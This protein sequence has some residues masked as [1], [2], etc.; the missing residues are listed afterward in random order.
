M[1]EKQLRWQLLAAVFLGVVYTLLFQDWASGLNVLLFDLLFLGIVGWLRPELRRTPA[2]VFSAATLLFS[3][4]C[5][6]LVHSWVAS[7]S[8]LICFWWFLGVCQAR[9]LRYLWFSLL[10]GLWSL[11]GGWKRALRYGVAVWRTPDRPSGS[12]RLALPWLRVAVVPMVVVFPFFLFYVAGNAAFAEFV[13]GLADWLGHWSWPDFDGSL[14]LLGFFGTTLGLAVLLPRQSSPR[15]LRYA[16]A[17]GDD[18]VRRRER[19]WFGFEGALALLR[20]YRMGVICFGF[21]NVL[22][23]LVNAFDL[24]Y[25]WFATATPSAAQLS[26]YVHEGTTSLTVSIFCA[27]LLVLYFFRGSLNFLPRARPLYVLAYLWLGQN[28]LLALSVAVR[29]GRYIAAYGLAEGRIIVAF[30]LLLACLGLWSLYRK[31]RYRKSLAYLFQRNGL[32]TLA[33]LLVFSA[34]NWNVL[35]TRY[36]LNVPTRAGIDWDY[37][38]HGLPGRDNL[39][40]LV[41]QEHQPATARHLERKR[42]LAAARQDYLATSWLAWNWPAYRNARAAGAW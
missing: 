17:L 20:E 11:P 27:M 33:L 40:L 29:N 35:I 18:L 41:R 5:I 32:N 16:A 23:F 31:V 25:I 4:G 9:E 13:G 3:S 22:L 19:S 24:R 42:K 39:F 21:L 1:I 12:W 10:L 8:H 28:A 38:D 36:N 37:L 2:A 30:F 7:F 14:L 15:L 34:I 26:Q 6:V